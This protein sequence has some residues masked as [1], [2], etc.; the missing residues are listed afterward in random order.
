MVQSL[1]TKGD[2]FE[3]PYFLYS[4]IYLN[5]VNFDF[6]SLF[7][8]SIACMCYCHQQVCR[9]FAENT[10]AGFIQDKLK[11]SIYLSLDKYK[12]TK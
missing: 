10:V 7:Y 1:Q 3:S 11:I 6:S 2:K 12:C 8:L 5:H 4:F 9:L